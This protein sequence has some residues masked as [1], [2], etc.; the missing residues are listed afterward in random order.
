M[1]DRTDP[2]VVVD[3]AESYGAAYFASH[4]GP[5]PYARNERVWL[6]FFGHVAERIVSTLRPSS[7]FDAGCAIG[8]LVEELRKRGV[9]ADGRDIS[10]YAIAQV[11]PGLKRYCHVGSI[12]DEIESKYD[13]VTCIEVLEHMP[14]EEALRAIE[15]MT[16]A[17]PRI[18][19]S[20]SP[21]DFRESTHINVRPT[22][23]WLRKFQGMG[24]Y[25]VF[26]YDASY[27]C[28]Q[29]MLLEARKEKLFPYELEAYAE[30]VQMRLTS[31]KAKA[32]AEKDV[33]ERDAAS[34]AMRDESSQAAR[35]YHQQLTTVQ[36]A[37]TQLREANTNFTRSIAERDTQLM[38]LKRQCSQHNADIA[39]LQLG[40]KLSQLEEAKANLVRAVA[41]KDSRLS[42]LLIEVE[43][44]GE[45]VKQ[46][47]KSLR[48]RSAELEELRSFSEWKIGELE[49][50][51]RG[52]SESFSWSV[53]RP[54]REVGRWVRRLGG[55]PNPIRAV[56]K[57]TRP[58]RY[59]LMGKSLAQI[60]GLGKGQ[61]RQGQQ[62]GSGSPVGFLKGLRKKTRPIRYFLMG[63]KL[64]PK[65]THSPC[66]VMENT[67]EALVG[68]DLHNIDFDENTYLSVNPDVARSVRDGAFGSA[69]VHFLRYGINEI[70]TSHWRVFRFKL[71]N[72]WFDFDEAV[73]LADNADL[74]QRVACGTYRSGWDYFLRAGYAE[75]RDGTRALYG[76]HRFVRLVQ[77]LKGVA[78]RSQSCRRLVLFAHYDRDGVI[79]DY[80]L[81][82]LGALSKL[83]ADICVITAVA[84]PK[85]LEKVRN[86]AFCIIIKNDA[87]RDFGS[88][89]LALKTLDSE[90]LNSYDHV[91]FVNDSI[92][93]PVAEPNEFF[94][95]MRDSKLNLLGLTDS[96]AFGVYHAQS[97]WLAFDRTAQEVVLP[98]FIRR[99]ESTPY[100][101]KAGQ[102]ASFEMGLSKFAAAQGLTV[103]AYCSIDTISEDVMRK[104]HLMKWRSAV[105][106]GGGDVNSTHHLWD[107][108]IRHYRCPGIK[109][110]LLRGNPLRVP[111][112]D[113][114]R[115]INTDFV[116]VAVL[117]RHLHRIGINREPI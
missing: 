77:Q 1:A 14:E 29:T 64:V 18:L 37:L 58:V 107:L 39:T 88:W 11:P 44:R 66:T 111:V 72:L 43:E 117:E 13:L 40:A 34:R 114:P 27:I 2:Q 7:V 21:D 24:F 82:Y 59:F 36:E 69:R 116:S 73:Y 108:L 9:Q 30:I 99:F 15:S 97:Y 23:Y 28:P 90:I 61:V 75:C 85:E 55:L 102:I 53:T 93:F 86:M 5:Q 42:A 48:Q 92:Y 74:R 26:F 80:V 51:L 16:K 101:T 32:A 17:A 8:F 67:A 54:L 33:S 109:I 19:F 91:V 105:Q 22:I 89:Y 62:G 112:T 4:C 103:G 87:G 35:D 76:A 25:P 3:P 10:P 81:T 12:A 110:E 104:Q 100:M 45:S 78:T 41:E 20:S 115:I 50:K 68:L 98:E 95:W 49:D 46:M 79:D 63:K 47:R 96:R 31:A 83:G 106:M 60:D 6:D 56:R 65:G 57:K 70:P 94:A 52:I 71:G 38:A 113:W 84:D